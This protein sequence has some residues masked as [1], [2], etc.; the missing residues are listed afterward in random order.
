MCKMAKFNLLKYKY[1]KKE[2]KL[3]GKNYMQYII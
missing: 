2:G 1:I 3:N